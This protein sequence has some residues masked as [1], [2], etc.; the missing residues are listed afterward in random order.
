[1]K[2]VVNLKDAIQADRD[3][4]TLPLVTAPFGHASQ[5]CILLFQK[6]HQTQISLLAKSLWK[7]Y[8][9]RNFEWNLENVKK[10]TSLGKK[11]IAWR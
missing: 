2:H 5:V 10:V 1:M 9:L 6:C 7:L 3:D 4:P 11:V 8:K